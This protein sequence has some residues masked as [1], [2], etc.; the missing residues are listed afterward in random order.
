MALETSSPKVGAAGE[1]QSD[2][3]PR[4]MKAGRRRNRKNKRRNQYVFEVSI[5]R[6]IIDVKGTPHWRRRNGGTRLI[7]T[8]IFKEGG[9]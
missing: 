3:N 8:S 5:T 2:S 9:M 4:G 6:A 7:G 1:Q